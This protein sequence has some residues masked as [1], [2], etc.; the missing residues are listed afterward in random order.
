MRLRSILLIT[1][2]LTSSR[3]AIKE[4]MPKDEG[5]MRD[6]S[7]NIKPKKV[8]LMPKER[9]E[10]LKASLKICLTDFDKLRENFGELIEDIGRIIK[11]GTSEEVR[12]AYPIIGELANSK[13]TKLRASLGVVE[14]SNIVELCLLAMANDPDK[15]QQI[16][17]A[18][19]LLMSLQVSDRTRLGESDQH[20][21]DRRGENRFEATLRRAAEGA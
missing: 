19:I 17:I 10:L 11:E 7:L 14:P 8:N 12:E 3:C 13:V 16:G 1:I 5:C 21:G 9:I 20:L 15:T 18:A 2:A 4:E 6:Y